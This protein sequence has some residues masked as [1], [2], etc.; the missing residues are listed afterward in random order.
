MILGITGTAFSGKNS[1]IDFLVEKGFKHYSIN[2]F[3]EEEIKKR[4]LIVNEDTMIAIKEQIFSINHPGYIAE[5]IYAKAKSAEGNCIIETITMVGELEFLKTKEDFH[6][7]AIDADS[8]TRYNRSIRNKT[9]SGIITY[10]E[11]LEAEKDELLSYEM[12]QQ[13]LGRCMELADFIILNN[14]TLEAL[15]LEIVKI[16]SKLSETKQEKNTIPKND[17]FMGIALLAGK[18]SQDSNSKKGSCLVDLNGKVLGIGW[19]EFPIAGLVNEPL[20]SKKNLLCHSQLNSILASSSTKD[21]TLY[22]G[23]FPCIEC[24]KSI[25]Q[26]EIKKIF[27]LEENELK[28]SKEAKELLSLAGIRYEQLI[29]KER[30]ISL[31]F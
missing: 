9:E 21:S 14:G 3:L 12:T 19:E 25:V 5:Q 13:N 27:Y 18:M 2:Y 11:F 23:E 31:E 8:K 6:L 17:F 28:S 22:S 16:F 15:Y 20:N 1:V 30:K 7:I 24:I 29:P 10:D 4:G 26:T